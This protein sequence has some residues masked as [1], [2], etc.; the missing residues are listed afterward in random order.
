MHVTS[1]ICPNCNAPLPTERTGFTFCP[2]C[3]HKVVVEEETVRMRFDNA[4]EAGKDF[5]RGRQDAEDREANYALADKLERTR[6][7]LLRIDNLTECISETSKSLQSMKETRI[8]IGWWIAVGFVAL[9]FMRSSTWISIF[10][11]VAGFGSIYMANKKKKQVSDSIRWEKE[12]AIESMSQELDELKDSEFAISLP[13]KYMQVDVLDQLHS[14][15]LSCRAYTLR[16]A[17][18]CYEEDL[19]RR[20]VEKLERE[21]LE[22]QRQQIDIQKEQIDVLKQNGKNTKNNKSA[23]RALL[24][25]GM[26]IASIALLGKW[27]RF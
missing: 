25:A 15:V 22:V 27:K 6:K 23:G 14:I 19:H 20:A 7:K 24:G 8:G 26:T 13:R 5:E 16:Q 12:D 9:L 2:Y 18:N 10:I 1:L 4:Y 3:G 17:I 21:K 11:L